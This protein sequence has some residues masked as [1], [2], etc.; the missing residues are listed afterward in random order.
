MHSVAGVGQIK[1]APDWVRNIPVTGDAF[2]GIGISSIQES[3]DYRSLANKMALKDLAEKIFVSINSESEV[4]LSYANNKAVYE[5][6]ELTEFESSNFLSGHQKVTDWTDNRSKNY[7]VLFKLNRFSYLENRRDYFQRVHEML[8]IM[9]SEADQLIDEGSLIRGINKLSD[10]LLRIE[11][12]MQRTMEPEYRVNLEKTQLSFL[13]K[14]EQQLSRLSFKT[15]KYYHFDLLNPEP[16]IIKHFLIDRITGLPVPHT[17]SRIKVYRGDVFNY[18][19]SR[20][21]EFEE[22]S[23]KGIFPENGVS[24]IKISLEVSIPE[25]VKA[26]LDPALSSYF[27]SSSIFLKFIPYSIYYDSK[28]QNSKGKEVSPRLTDYLRSITEDLGFVTVTD[29]L[30]DMIIEVN[31]THYSNHLHRGHY[32][33][34]FESAIK[35]IDTR[36]SSEVYHFSFEIQKVV[37]SKRSTAVNRAY[38]ATVSENKKFLVSFVTFLCTKQEF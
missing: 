11:S 17:K 14:L 38:A 27:E 26:M 31:S 25:Q 23:I 10:A 36:K 15:Q 20:N 7:Y 19:I 21:Q 2:Y 33:G 1:N 35:G 13:Y 3:S 4:S 28:E 29:S 30:S 37:A 8:I 34:V 12:E 5:I 22:L 32:E 16:L 6:E 24:E 18:Q 9:G